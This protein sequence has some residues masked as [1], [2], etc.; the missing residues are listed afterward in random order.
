[1]SRIASPIDC[2]VIPARAAMSE[3]APRRVQRRE[4][5]VVRRPD[6][7][8]SARVPRAE[9]VRREQAGNRSTIAISG[10]RWIIGSS[11]GLTFDRLPSYIRQVTLPYRARTRHDRG[12]HRRPRCPIIERVGSGLFPARRQPRSTGSASSRSCW[13]ST[14]LPGTR[15][16]STGY[17]AP[18]RAHT[19]PMGSRSSP[20][21]RSSS[22]CPARRA[23]AE[24]AGCFTC[25]GR[26]AERGAALTPASGSRRHRS[27]RARSTDCRCSCA[28]PATSRCR[29]TSTGSVPRAGG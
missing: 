27:T 22:T 29:P 9:H 11:G 16:R 5:G 20:A 25:R 18:W 15:S 8:M 14:P 2:L 19:W 21:A 17:A 28:A 3:R 4:D 24:L 13:P 6:L 7:R 10:F 1:M 12:R 23:R 26:G